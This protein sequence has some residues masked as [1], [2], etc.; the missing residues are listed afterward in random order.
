MKPSRETHGVSRSASAGETRGH[1]TNSAE[2]RGR[3]VSTGTSH[4]DTMSESETYGTSSSDAYG[5]SEAWSAQTSRSEGESGSESK[6]T[7]EG[8][9]F[10]PMLMPIM[11]RELSSR[12]FRPIE[13]Q[14]F[15]FS[16]LLD[17]L[18]DRHCVVRLA[19]MRSPLPLYVPTVRKPL[20][21]PRWVARW[22][23]ARLAALPF[24]LPIAVALKAVAERE[25]SFAT[26]LLPDASAEPSTARRRISG[27]SNRDGSEPRGR[28]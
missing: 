17:G 11:G 21:T 3:S 24:A 27:D 19:S 13:E 22:T 8:V 12:Q 7:S 28:P 18:P 26:R 10:S 14:L 16:Q 23:L 5:G 15:R 6:S 1:S 9:S 25:G 2:S 20:T 4:A